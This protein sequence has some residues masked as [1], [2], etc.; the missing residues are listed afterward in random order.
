MESN[1][2][3]NLKTEKKSYELEILGGREKKKDF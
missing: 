2:L 3:Q 1:I